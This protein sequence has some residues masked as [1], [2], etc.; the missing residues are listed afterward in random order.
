MNEKFPIRAQKFPSVFSGV[1]INWFLPW[2]EEA[3]VAVAQ[4]FL[5]P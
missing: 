3:L 1:A 5:G 4:A 2:P